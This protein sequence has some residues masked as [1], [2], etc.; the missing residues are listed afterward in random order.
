MGRSMA[1][2]SGSFSINAGLESA[3]LTDGAVEVSFG[4][5]VEDIAPTASEIF[6]INSGFPMTEDSISARLFSGKAGFLSS[7]RYRSVRALFKVAE[8]IGGP[9]QIFIR[10]T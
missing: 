8:L 1:I 4:W 5:S 7:I 10:G 9:C 6:F 3:S 2:T